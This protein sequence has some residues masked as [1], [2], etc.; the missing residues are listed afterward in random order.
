MRSDADRGDARG[1]DAP[2]PTKIPV[3]IL[4]ATGSVGQTFVELLAAHP[5][6][7]ITAL[8]ASPASAGRPYREVAG[9]FRQTPL[10]DAVAGMRV[11][12]CEPDLPC[13]IVFS[14]LDASVAGEI[15]ERFARAG[16]IVVSNAR[17]HR[18]D[19]D[20][21]L[22]VP[23]VNGEH[24]ELIKQQP[25]GSGAIVTNPNCSTIGLV[26][27]LKPLLDA[28]GLEAVHVVTMQAISGAG[29][30]GVPSLD[31][32]DN[33]IPFIGGEEQKVERE[34]RKILG[35]Y[36]DG[37]VE[38]RELPI[39]AQCNRVGVLD[40]HTECVSV[41]LRE[42]PQ[43]PEIIAAWQRFAGLP[44]AL[45]LPLAPR[46]PV[47]YMPEVNFP[48][49]R[50]HRNLERGMAVSIG[51]LRECPLFDYKFVLCVHNAVRGAAGGAVLNAELMVRQGLI[52]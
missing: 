30:P 52:T 27:A 26:L 16:Y 47:H 19:A 36:R 10:P 50:I 14:A 18:L 12:R 25:Y 17:N 24:L 6:F 4:G 20:V 51:R 22:L 7:E 5:W 31:I 35:T 3:G 13:R 49:P 41:K 32:A 45:D 15:E 29:Y 11:E 1:G 43:P 37:Q 28:F 21:P 40:G 39:S 8:A 48:Q 2:A 46:Q 33:V 38:H 9:W 42:K 34:P 44:Q 23:E